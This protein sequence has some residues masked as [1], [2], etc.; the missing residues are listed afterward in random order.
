MCADLDGGRRLPRPQP[1]RSNRWNRVPAHAQGPRAGRG[2]E[3]SSPTPAQGSKPRSRR[4]CWV[5]PAALP[6][7]LC[8]HFVLARVPKGDAEMMAATIG[9][10]CA[11][12]DA[13]DVHAQLDVTAGMLGRQIPQVRAVLREAADGLPAFT[14]FPLGH[15]EVI[16][17]ANPL[18][19][20]NKEIEGR[21]DAVGV[22]PTRPRYSG[23]RESCWSRRMRNGRYPTA[24]TPPRA[25]WPS[26]TDPTPTRRSHSRPDGVIVPTEEAPRGTELHQDRGGHTAVVPP[27]CLSCQP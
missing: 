17:P 7:A 13:E 5:W 2:A 9:A 16:W 21:T 24:A 15:T 26:S 8:Q 3:W 6:G 27:S 12:P 20:L 22:F 11:Q 19:R 23:L 4:W 25:P 14:A 1:G 10:G 18:D